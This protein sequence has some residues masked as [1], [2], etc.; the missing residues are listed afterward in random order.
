VVVYEIY[1]RSFKDTNGDGIGDPKGIIEKL[2]YLNDGTDAS[3]GITAIWLNPIYKSPMKDFGLVA[4]A[5]KRNIKIIMDFVP[6]HT[7]SE[8]PWFQESKKAKDN[9]KRDWYIWRDPKTDGSP[10]NNWLSVFGGSA[11]TRDK[12]TGQYYLHSFLPNQPDLNW[13]NKY[14][15]DEMADVLRF[16]LKRG[17]NGFR[18][19]AV[20]HLIKDDE[21]RDDP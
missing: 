9:S 5:H 1:P 2:D 6:N 15:R 14:V 17:V 21:F 19:D 16:W 12:K 20:Y 10:P 8:H 7:S 13:R 3:L 18:T 4:K 11:W